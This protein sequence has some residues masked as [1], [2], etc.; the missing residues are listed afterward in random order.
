MRN[1]TRSYVRN[2]FGLLALLGTVS[3]S[4]NHSRFSPVAPDGPIDDADA[5]MSKYDGKSYRAVM[6]VKR[7]DDNQRRFVGATAL[8]MSFDRANKRLRLRSSGSF[9]Q[10]AIGNVSSFNPTSPLADP[11]PVVY[12]IF[13]TAEYED[14]FSSLWTNQAAATATTRSDVA[15]DQL[16]VNTYSLPS[17][18]PSTGVVDF[19]VNHA[20]RVE[21]AG[22]ETDLGVTASIELAYASDQL[23][24]ATVTINID[25]VSYIMEVSAGDLGLEQVPDDIVIAF[26][27]D[28]DCGGRVRNIAVHSTAILVGTVAAG[29]IFAEAATVAPLTVVARASFTIVAGG[30]RSWSKGAWAGPA[31]VG[32]TIGN[33]LNDTYNEIQDYRQHC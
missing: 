32:A 19:A 16:G 3:C 25:A 31:A 4:E 24:G 30:A 29:V 12:P 14:A 27:R 33:F 20:G 6:Y 9:T 2:V 18:F 15:T 17:Q 8:S 5:R 21:N 13:W 11:N 23:A 10:P 1:R 28:L 26:L 22:L 7:K